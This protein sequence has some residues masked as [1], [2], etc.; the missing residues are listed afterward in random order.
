MIYL[1]T[2]L[3]NNKRDQETNKLMG[4]VIFLIL[5]LV[6]TI[7]ISV[8][9][10][11]VYFDDY[12]SIQKQYKLLE[13]KLQKISVENYEKNSDNTRLNVEL[14]QVKNEVNKL[15]L[16]KEVSDKNIKLVEEFIE[17]VNSGNI[18]ESNKFLDPDRESEFLIEE[19]QK[20]P[21]EMA[22]GDFVLNDNLESGTVTY[23]Y[24]EENSRT[25]KYVFN[26]VLKD[27]DW[28]ISDLEIFEYTGEPEVLLN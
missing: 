7:V 20:F 17:S 4:V 26:M 14:N 3:F 15:N 11:L 9:V 22:S 10:F 6:F 25:D 1:S 2:Y 27:E 24:T 13:E 19:D 18:K 28:L 5:S 12:M 16:E 23:F 8:S 21:D